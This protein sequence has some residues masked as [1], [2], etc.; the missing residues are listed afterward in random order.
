MTPTK[1]LYNFNLNFT[2]GYDFHF[3]VFQIHF[4]FFPFDFGQDAKWILNSFAH[5]AYV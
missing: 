5:N 2:F 1:L 4:E 3:S